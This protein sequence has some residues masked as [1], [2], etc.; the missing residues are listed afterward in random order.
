M[1]TRNQDEKTNRSSR[2]SEERT[3]EERPMSWT[4]PSVLPTPEDDNDWVYRWVRTSM[5]GQADN[6]NVSM[7]FREG[8]EP[9]K[10]DDYPELMVVP[11][12][13]S[14]WGK[15]GAIEIGGLI[16]CRA[17]RE[18]REQ[19]QRYHDQLGRA[20]IEAIDNNFMREQDP[21][22]PLLAPERKTRF[23]GAE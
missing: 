5:M 13:N 22:M 6:R 17:P 7:R 12:H 18:M 16:L 14:E 20:Q 9:V 21:R 3:N 19:R 10:G 11:D 15:K 23:G 2:S 4:P 8:W 1:S